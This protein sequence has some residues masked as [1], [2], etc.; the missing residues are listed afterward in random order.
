[1]NSDFY[2]YQI[3]DVVSFGNHDGL[4]YCFPKT[5]E[6]IVCKVRFAHEEIYKI[7]RQE[8]QLQTKE[9]LANKTENGSN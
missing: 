6:D 5:K 8:K 1:V 3:G 4:F 2:F 7:I 9:A